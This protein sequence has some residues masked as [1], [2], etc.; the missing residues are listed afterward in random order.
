MSTVEQIL[1]GSNKTISLLTYSKMLGGEEFTIDGNLLSCSEITENPTDLAGHVDNYFIGI[2]TLGVML[3]IYQIL[4]YLMYIYSWYSST[5]HNIK[6]RLL[7]L[8][9]YMRD[10]DTIIQKMQ[11]GSGGNRRTE[12]LRRIREKY[13][14]FI[15]ADKFC[16]IKYENPVHKKSKFYRKCWCCGQLPTPKYL[17]ELCEY[18][19]TYAL[20]NGSF[21]YVKDTI[22]YDKDKK[23]VKWTNKNVKK[24]WKNL[25]GYATNFDSKKIAILRQVYKDASWYYFVVY[26]LTLGYVCG[27]PSIHEAEPLYVETKDVFFGRYEPFIADPDMKPINLD[28]NLYITTI[29]G[30]K[31]KTLHRKVNGIDDSCSRFFCG[32]W[33]G[34][35]LQDMELALKS[36][37]NE[38]QLKADLDINF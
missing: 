17:Y 19:E 28:E 26:I 30:E 22:R 7:P 12:H 10:I 23:E 38:E 37:F 9:I 14:A 35:T 34:W 2:S 1:A 4:S 33:L 25:K 24:R 6:V 15:E 27:A 31:I 8:Q 29:N 13:Y 11:I 3:L 5:G 32:W 20:K 21:G 18:K 36:E 16:W